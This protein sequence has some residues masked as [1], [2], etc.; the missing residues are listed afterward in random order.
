MQGSP[1]PADSGLLLVGDLDKPLG[2]SALTLENRMDGGGKEK[3]KKRL[4]LI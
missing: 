1:V 4:Q 2:W 3:S